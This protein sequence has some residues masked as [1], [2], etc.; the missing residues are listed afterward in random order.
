MNPNRTHTA[1]WLWKHEFSRELINAV[2][3]WTYEELL[4]VIT[5]QGRVCH[6]DR[7]IITHIELQRLY[8][9]LWL[10]SNDPSDYYDHHVIESLI[11][12][13]HPTHTT[14][15]TQTPHTIDPQ[16]SANA[17]IGTAGNPIAVHDHFGEFDPGYNMA[18]FDT[19]PF[20][21][22][23]N[24]PVNWDTPDT[25]GNST[26]LGWGGNTM[27]PEATPFNWG[28]SDI[29]APPGQ[30]GWSTPSAPAPTKSAFNWGGVGAS[31]GTYCF[32]QGAGNE[33]WEDHVVQ[34]QSSTSSDSETTNSDLSN[35]DTI[36]SMTGEATDIKLEGTHQEITDLLRSYTDLK[37][38]KDISK[39]ATQTSHKGFDADEIHDIFFKD[40]K[41]GDQLLFHVHG[42]D[43][44]T[45]KKSHRKMTEAVWVRHVILHEVHA[46]WGFTKWCLSKHRLKYNCKG[47][48]FNSINTI[49]DFLCP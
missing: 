29:P 42:S 39:W 38:T 36:T 2:G 8:Y 9:R 1:K 3:H 46:K 6:L 47:S 26:Q 15:T 33:M 12:S 40:T 32:N 14:H 11:H 24:A 10:I 41:G 30:F 22:W 31:G 27:A 34:S 5:P 13:S 48:T 49:V 37:V 16:G 43:I 25:S 7:T 28:T 17:D 21:P 45:P 20:T 18:G 35:S 19:P 44:V 23:V 4:E